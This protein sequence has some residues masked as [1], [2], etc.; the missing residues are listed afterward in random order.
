MAVLKSFG[1]LVALPSHLDGDIQHEPRLSCVSHTH[2]ADPICIAHTHLLQRKSKQ[3][4]LAP[5]A[6][7]ET[8]CWGNP[9]SAHPVES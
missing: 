5:H 2:H 8:Q 9:V 6:S 4:A 3:S 7:Q 1:K